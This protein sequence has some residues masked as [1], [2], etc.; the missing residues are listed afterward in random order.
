MNQYQKE[1]EQLLAL[2]DKKVSKE[3]FNL[4]VDTI[5]DLKKSLLVEYQNFEN[6][7]RSKKMDLKRMDALL[8]TLERRTEALKD[9]LNGII[10]QH[11]KSASKL[12]YNELFY[13]YEQTHTGLNFALLKEDELEVLIN[14]PVAGFRLSER[15]NDGVVP[16]LKKGIKSELERS[17]LHGDSYAKT[18]KRLSQVGAASYSRAMR[19]ARTEAGRVSS[20]ARQKSQLEAQSLGVE[21]K[22][23]WSAV[24]DKRTRHN[25]QELDGQAVDPEGYFEIG[26]NKTLQPKMFG[27][28]SEDINCRCRTISSFE[29][30]DTPLLKRDNETGEVGEWKN[31]REWEKAK[32]GQ[33]QELVAEKVV[34]SEKKRLLDLQ[35]RAIQS[36]EQSN[37]RQSVGLA[38]FNQF[39]DKFDT[40]SDRDTLALYQKFGSK[41][42]YYNLKGSDNFAKG[43][44]VQLSQD[45]FDGK[46]AKSV[47]NYWAKPLSTVFHENGHAIDKL[48]LDVLTK[49]ERVVVGEKNVRLYGKT[50]KVSVFAS[51]ASSLPQYKLKQT[52]QNDLWKYVN[53]GLPMKLTPT[54]KTKIDRTVKA[55]LVKFKNEM[56]SLHRDNPSAVATL[57]DVTEA[58][59]WFKESK[60]F[61]YGHGRGYWKNTGAAEAE[62]FAEVSEAIANDLKAYE[63]IKRILPNAVDV[64]H[65]IVKDI[66]GGS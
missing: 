4:Y 27:I 26:G 62:F 2:Q 59:D 66:L 63:E 11:V 6:L 13:E 41:I 17:F 21:F 35:G 1:M 52:I 43:H 38:N 32:T 53:D 56:L 19:I 34:D 57:S 24:F 37:M 61:G 10:P 25:H 36:I 51:H 46:I 64:Y 50:G 40:I 39:L 7:S 65:K 18:A 47:G 60:P 29:D 55:N 42:E 33:G 16:D 12:A 3:L 8:E 22:K 5:K 48:G 58:T 54:G 45:A 49:G 28:A 15:L 30:D 20:I 23:V 14:T 44:R 9:G 31:Y